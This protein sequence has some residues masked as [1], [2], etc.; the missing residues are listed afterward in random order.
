MRFVSVREECEVCVSR[1][2]VR[3]V[4]VREECEVCV[5]EESVKCQ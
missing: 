2:S 4:S 3:C 5:S 1:E